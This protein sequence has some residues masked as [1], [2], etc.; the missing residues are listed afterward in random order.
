MLDRF[1]RTGFNTGAA[2][3]TLVDVNR[4]GLAV[5]HFINF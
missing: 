5:L 3:N 4:D 1:F 2:F